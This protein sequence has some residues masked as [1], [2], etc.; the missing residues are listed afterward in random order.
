MS[1]ENSSKKNSGKKETKDIV[2]TVTG[3]R[4]LD[5]VTTI[6]PLVVLIALCA[7]F[8]IAP[9]ASTNVLSTIRNFLGTE[10]GLYY[11]VVALGIFLVSLYISF[12]DLGKVRLGGKDEK[13]KYGFFAWGAMVFCCG[14]AADILFY[15]FCEWIY[16]AE[17]PRVAEMGRI[18]DWANAIPL[19]H[20]GPIV[21]SFYAVLAACF[22]FMIHVRGS[23]KQKYSEAC[24]PILG[25]HTD[26]VLGKIIDILAIVALIAGTATTF[27]VATPLLGS[28]LTTLFGIP[29]T[30]WVTIAILLVTCATYTTSVM[31]GMKGVNNLSKICMVLFGL[32]LM[33]VLVFSGKAVYILENGFS[34]LGLVVQNFPVLSTYTDALRENGFAQN[35]TMYYWAYWLVW[36]VAAPFFMGN[37]SRGR[38]VKQ[39]ILGTYAFGLASTLISFIVLGNYGLGLQV[40]GEFDAI[41]MYEANGYDLY[42]VIIEIIKTLPGYQ[43]V[44]VLLILSMIAFYAT[45]FDSIT[46][47]ASSYSYKNMRG[48]EMAS[49][50][51][52]LFW[53]MLL[54]LLPIA[55]IFSES[56]M[57]NIQSVSIIAAFPVGMVIILIIA[58]FIKDARK[59]ID[60]Q[61]EPADFFEETEINEDEMD[62]SERKLQVKK[63]AK[64]IS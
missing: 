23:K 40:S 64:K 35:W 6:A 10:L 15:S 13:P 2:K 17:E 11:L 60:N 29:Y 25:K 56:S 47:V 45:S 12:S 48:D 44:L 53:A 4:K 14:L 54:I 51:M 20:W 41:G 55:L 19:Y 3:G 33:F 28:A 27:S 30:K 22:G 38:T 18:E 43:V 34:S 42:A 16:Y 24:R 31:I 7:T 26:G 5:P 62:L 59:Y 8:V 57:N 21:W 50:K 39:V 37:I 63:S 36:C 32:I 49:K 58:S 9:E 52:K 61:E 46:L 1:K